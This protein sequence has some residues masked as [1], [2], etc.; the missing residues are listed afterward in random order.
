MSAVLAVG[1]CGCGGPSSSIRAVGPTYEVTT[2]QIGGLGTVLIDGK[3]FTLYL[4]LPDDH[5]GHSRCTGIC[6]AAWPPLLA[7][8]TS[9]PVAGRGINPPL[10]GTTIRSDGTRQVT[11]NGWPLYRYAIDTAPGQAAGQGLNNLGGL[12]YVVSPRGSPVES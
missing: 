1:L 9:S 4:F 6:A 2:A 12:W 11:Y 7:P 10:L 5:T 3:G 8:G